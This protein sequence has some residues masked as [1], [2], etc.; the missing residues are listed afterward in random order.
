MNNL[1]LLAAVD[2]MGDTEQEYADIK[3]SVTDLFLGYD[4]D[5][6][7]SEGA[8][9][10]PQNIKSQPFNIYVFD[11]GGLLPGADDLTRSIYHSL[12][13]LVRKYP[14]RLFIMWSSFTEQWYKEICTEEFPEFIAPNVI[15]RADENLVERCH[16]FWFGKS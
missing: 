7:H 6:H 11:W 13:G 1:I 15:F 3:E 16:K 14:Q 9:L 5:Y 12:L 10:P 4:I 8:E 2:Y